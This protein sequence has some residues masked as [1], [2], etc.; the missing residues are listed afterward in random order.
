MFLSSGLRVRLEWTDVGFHY[1]ATPPSDS[2]SK[3][4]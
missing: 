3:S 4:L 1:A 2:V